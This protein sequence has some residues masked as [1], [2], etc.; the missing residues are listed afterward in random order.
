[1]AW[2]FHERC[3]SSLEADYLPSFFA[4]GVQ[5][6]RQAA[7]QAAEGSDGGVCA[8][9]ASLLTAILSWEFQCAPLSLF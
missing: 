5:V 6:A 4:H 7:P 9:C 1:M 2:D 3:R 8:A